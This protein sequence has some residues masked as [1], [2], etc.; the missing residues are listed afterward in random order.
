MF[1]L[2]LSFFV[3]GCKQSC[4]KVLFLHLSVSHSVHIGACMVGGICSG[5]HA[6]GMCMAGVCGGMHG[7]VH[8]WQGA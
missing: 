1:L 3:T 4:R 5:G 2:C 8:V 6:W 7:R